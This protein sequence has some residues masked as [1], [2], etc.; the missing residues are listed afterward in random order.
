MSC[1]RVDRESYARDAWPRGLIEMARGK[2]PETLPDVIVWPEHEREIV[3]I[4]KYASRKHVPVVPWGAGSGVCG[5]AVPV[6]GGIVVDLK[7][8]D[9]M[10]ACE[11]FDHRATFQCGI[12]GQ[13]LEDALSRR[14]LTLGHF[15]SSIQCSTLGGWVAARSAGQCSSRYGKIEDMV[16][17]LRAVS[18]AGE[19]V[20]TDVERAGDLT[21]L[22]LGSE[23]TLAV[24]V[25]ARLRI[26]SAPEERMLRGY[27]FADISSGCEGMRRVMQMGLRPAVL[28]LYDP[29][30]TLLASSGDHGQGALARLGALV[31]PA[32]R[33]R[34][35]SF[36][37]DH[38]AP[39]GR[40]L[41]ATLGRARGCLLIAGF[42]GTRD[43]AQIEAKLGHDALLA[44]GATD[45]GPEPG[46]RWFANR[47]KVSYQQSR[48][49]AAGAFV[50]TMEVATTW[51]H[52]AELYDS[53]RRAI[54]QRAFVMAHMS[55]AYPEGCSI[56]FTFIASMDGGERLYDGIW[57]AALGASMRSHG[58]LSHHHG[59]GLQKT[60]WMAR[61]HGDALRLLRAAKRAFDPAGIMNPGKLLS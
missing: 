26:Q 55:H 54:A 36:A 6:A 15:P 57:E 34:A 60:P 37:A 46:Q 42:E 9:R 4:L 22:L 41:S 25:D 51:G 11:P 2:L 27:R 28:R 56:Y 40:A 59:I 45:L 10:T 38:A 50:D 7:R 32:L 8:M 33:R 17:G 44:A 39:I 16:L 31:S 24:I 48:V 23:G 52:L 19:P 49:F 14:G 47:Y 20:R 1:V 21:P 35:T 3:A 13:T 18:G 53:V 58:A 29:I 61:E 12:L 5:A 43:R 30:D